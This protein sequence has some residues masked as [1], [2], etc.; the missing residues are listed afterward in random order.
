VESSSNSSLAQTKRKPK[1]ASF[2]CKRAV[3]WHS[4][5]PV[6]FV[7]ASGAAAGYQVRPQISRPP[8]KNSLKTFNSVSS[9]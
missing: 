3:N 7:A 8:T 6:V 5:L 9:D 4:A 1:P 2:E